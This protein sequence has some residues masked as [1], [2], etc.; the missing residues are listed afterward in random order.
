VTGVCVCGGIKCY[1]VVY[2]EGKHRKIKDRDG[3]P[4]G[5]DKA[6]RQLEV[7]RA[8][9]DEGDFDI[10]DWLP[11]KLDEKLF[12]SLMEKWLEEKEKL[13]NQDALAY[14]TLAS[15]Q[16]INK[17]HFV[18]FEGKDVREIKKRHFKDFDTYLYENGLRFKSTKQTIFS[19]LHSFFN[20]LLKDQEVISKVPVFPDIEG[21]E[22]EPKTYLEYEDQQ[23]Y[24]KKLPDQ[25]R[26]IFAFGME[27]GLRSGELCSLQ[28][29]DIDPKRLDLIVTRTFSTGRRLHNKTK[30]KRTE[31]IP[32]SDTAIE[33][34]KRHAENKTA[35]SYLFLDNKG[36]PFYAHKLWWAWQRYVGVATP[37]EAMR[38]SFGNQLLDDGM[39]LEDLQI[40]LRHKTITTTMKYVHRK[41]ERLRDRINQRGKIKL[42]RNDPGTTRNESENANTL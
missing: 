26:D 39:P 14:S 12:E 38:H 19:C 13:F 34:I 31:R 32:L 20:W 22:S 8:K 23:E 7:M 41:S 17:K 15:Y 11:G 25:Y 5:Y 1:I 4:F 9:M 3:H 36:N 21:D 27:T 28:I 37:H 30:Q 2:W 35:G 10:D 42:I 18:F 24:L 33:I 6:K 40:A 29:K 16:S